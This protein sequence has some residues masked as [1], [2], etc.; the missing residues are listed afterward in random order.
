MLESPTTP[1]ALH[2]D[3]LEGFAVEAAPAADAGR[4]VAYCRQLV[5][6]LASEDQATAARLRMGHRPPGGLRR[7]VLDQG[8]AAAGWPSTASARKSSAAH[9][10]IDVGK[11]DTVPAELPPDLPPPAPAPIAPGGDRLRAYLHGE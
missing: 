1:V 7:H 9:Q 4:C 3:Q 6:H 8:I 10:P 5:D 11:L 2:V